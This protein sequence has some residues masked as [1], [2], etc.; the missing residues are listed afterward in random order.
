M[1][2]RGGS[3]VITGCGVV[4]PNGIGREAFGAALAEGRTGIGEIVS[5]DASDLGRER[6]AEIVDFD[7]EPF[8]RSPKNYLDRN[9]ALAFAACEMAVRESVAALPD[10]DRGHGLSLGSAGGNLETLALFHANVRDKGPRFAPPF[11]FPHTYY[12]ATA[13][14]LSME[15]GLTGP[16]EQFCSGGCAGLEAV[17]FA[18]ECVARGRADLIIAGGVESFTEPLFRMAAVRGLLSPPDGGAEHCRPFGRDRNGTI[19]GEGAALFVL[20][21]EQAARAR[22]ARVLGRVASMAIASSAGEAMCD[23]LARAHV[24]ADAVGAVFAAAGGYEREDEEEAFAIADLF[25]MKRV[26]VVALKG[27]I[28]ETLG[29]GGALNL[30]AAVSSM[31]TGVL[32]PVGDVTCAFEQLDL[33]CR[34]RPADLQLVLVNAGGPGGGWVSGVLSV[35]NAWAVE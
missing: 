4:A 23:A 28:G 11:L 3:T 30:A 14:L 7:A 21:S 16:H 26:P 10:T 19:L 20:E 31:Q 32:P 29:A 24:E 5:F 9:S 15:Y 1:M 13:A 12:N 2:S 33:V 27:L 18:A 35:G 8:L 22:N 17:A 34:P 25:G 6:A